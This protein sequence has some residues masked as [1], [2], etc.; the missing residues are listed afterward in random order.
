MDVGSIEDKEL[1]NYGDT[2]SG[3]SL[4]VSLKFYLGRQTQ[5]EN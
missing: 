5:L 2:L 4:K 3:H 1:T